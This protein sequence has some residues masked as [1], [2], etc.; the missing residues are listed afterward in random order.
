MIFPWGWSEAD[1]P[2]CYPG[3]CQEIAAAVRRLNPAS[4]ADCNPLPEKQLTTLA[5]L[6][7]QPSSGK[8]ISFW[9][10]GLAATF[11]RGALPK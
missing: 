2:P 1:Q 3:L 7:T 4:L 11:D 10:I 8:L 5:G 9:R 6:W